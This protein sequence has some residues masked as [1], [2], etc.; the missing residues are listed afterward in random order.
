MTYDPFVRVYFEDSG[1]EVTVRRSYAE[2]YDIPIL[3]GHPAIQAGTAMPAKFR[4]TVAEAAAAKKK[5]NPTG[6]DTASE[7][8][9]ESK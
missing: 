5:N 1:A 4:I 7:S 3:E 9:E 2:L 6:S 8:K